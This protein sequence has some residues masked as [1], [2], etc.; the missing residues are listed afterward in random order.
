MQQKIREKAKEKNILAI[1]LH[2]LL[3]LSTQ[4]LTS[5]Q[6]K[7]TT[8]EK[9]RKKKKEWAIYVYFFSYLATF[10]DGC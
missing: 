6:R 4:T 10:N 1:A 8:R 7:L 9:K 5:S 3:T 2:F